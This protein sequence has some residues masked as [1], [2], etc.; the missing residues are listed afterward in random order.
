[1]QGPTDVRVLALRKAEGLR[2]WGSPACKPH[3]FTRRGRWTGS[4]RIPLRG[5]Q[6]LVTLPGLGMTSRLPPRIQLLGWLLFSTP[7]PATR[8]CDTE[9]DLLLVRL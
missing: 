9:G 2:V 1:M 4:V 3:L 6:P 8:V 7:G 5:R